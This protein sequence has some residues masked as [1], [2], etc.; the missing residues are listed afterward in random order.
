MQKTEKTVF[1]NTSKKNT[2][3]NIWT[4]GA[5]E[6]N[7]GPVNFGGWGA[8]IYIGHNTEPVNIFG[9]SRNTTNQ[10]MEMLA[11]I[12]GLTF[13]KSI[14]GIVNIHTD[15]KFII[16]CITKNWWKNWLKN[17]WQT[18]EGEPVKNKELW[19]RMLNLFKRRNWNIKLIKVKAHNG[20]PDNE[21]AD[22]LAKTGL[23]QC[24]PSYQ[25][26]KK[27]MENFAEGFAESKKSEVIQE[28][29]YIS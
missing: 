14:S 26:R 15:S 22:Q 3:I 4:D 29:G 25:T 11:I 6:M 24:K 21:K 28:R 7:G 23:Q 27:F 13:V 2:I 16:N 10:A 19:V 18:K 12:E 1:S 17:N 5:C 9:G 8:V 20:N